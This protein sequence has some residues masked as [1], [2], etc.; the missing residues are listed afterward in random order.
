[1][2]LSLEAISFLSGK[3]VYEL[4]E[5]FTVIR[6]FGSKGK[7]FLLPFYTLD[8]IIVREVCRKYKNWSHFFH[9][10]RKKQFIPLPWK[11]GNFIV[12][13]INH[14]N[15]LI[16]HHEQLGLKEEKFVEVFDPNNKF[17]THM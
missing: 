4:F 5:E 9:D 3:G 1:L 7:P 16:G 10:K 2:R 11:I 8:K 17:T 15:E 6:L 14:L 12:K 13:H